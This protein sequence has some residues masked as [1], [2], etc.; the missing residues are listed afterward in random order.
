MNKLLACKYYYNKVNTIFPMWLQYIGW[1][2]IRP[3]R[4]INTNL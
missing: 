4:T 3:Y 2:K 1:P